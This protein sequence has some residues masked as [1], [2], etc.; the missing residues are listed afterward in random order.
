MRLGAMLMR[1]LGENVELSPPCSAASRT[2][3]AAG[4]ELQTD[5]QKHDRHNGPSAA[6]CTEPSRRS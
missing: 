6:A 3:G 5:E 1:K 4:S 2:C